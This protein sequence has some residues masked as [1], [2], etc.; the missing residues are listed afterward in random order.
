MTLII[1]LHRNGIV[2]FWCSFQYWLL[3]S[4][5]CLHLWVCFSAAAWMSPGY[6]S[7]RR[8]GGLCF[9]SITRG[10]AAHTWDGDLH[11]LTQTRAHSCSYGVNHWAISEQERSRHGGKHQET[12]EKSGD[13]GGKMSIWNKKRGEKKAEENISLKTQDKK[14][15]M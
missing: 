2:F 10:R 1:Y 14:R 6:S 11:T 9:S 4:H 3:S 13:Q 7:G 5:I 8:A 12:K 15:V